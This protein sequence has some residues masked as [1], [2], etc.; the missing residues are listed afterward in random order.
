MSAES[1]DPAWEGLEPD[2]AGEDAKRDEKAFAETL[3]YAEEK[4][5]RAAKIAE[6]LFREAIQAMKSGAQA[7]SGDPEQ[8]VEQA[9]RVVVE[10]VKARPVTALLG[11]FGVGVIVGL[12]LSSRGK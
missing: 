11:G 12:L 8:T 6:K 4:L 3:V 5:S 7:Y 9:R 10:R 2:R 1:V